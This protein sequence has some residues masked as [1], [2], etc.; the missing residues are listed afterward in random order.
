[1]LTSKGRWIHRK[2]AQFGRDQRGYVFMSIAHFLHINRPIHG[3]YFE[4]GCNEANTMRQAWDH[5]Q[6]LFDL[7][8]VGFDSFEGLP[9]IAKIDTQPI[10]EKGK[11]KFE[12]CRFK[13]LVLGHGMPHN[14]LKT[15]K[16]F[17]DTSLTPGL[18]ASLLPKKSSG[19]LYRL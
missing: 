9:E 14:K 11:L 3:Y 15:V 8:Y 10:W 2:Y 7:E 13:N 18:K 5:F 6:Y 16:G 12:E 4:F 17:Y 19:Y 1:M